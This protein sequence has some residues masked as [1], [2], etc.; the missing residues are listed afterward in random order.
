VHIYT[1]EPTKAIPYIE[2]AMRLDPELLNGQYV[3]FLGTAYFVAGEYETAATC[4][5]DRI[6][7]NPTTDLSRALLASAL[8]HLGRHEEA[9]QVWHELKGINPRYS[10]ADHFA[11]LPFKNPADADKLTD[12]LRKAGLVE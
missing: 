5:K 12:G 8:G 4:F 3:H 11:R 2:R 6:T 10:Y 1:G 9:R 7:I